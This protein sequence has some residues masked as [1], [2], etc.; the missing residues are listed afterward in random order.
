MAKGGEQSKT[1]AVVDVQNEIERMR[2]TVKNLQTIMMNQAI[3]P[4]MRRDLK[5]GVDVNSLG[6]LDN[7]DFKTA[8][9]MYLDS[10]HIEGFTM[11]AVQKEAY[12]YME[13]LNT[14]K[15]VNV[16]LF[17]DFKNELG[18]IRYNEK[19]EKGKKIIKLEDRVY[20]TIEKSF[21]KRLST[22]YGLQELVRETFKEQV[23]RNANPFFQSRANGKD[24]DIPAMSKSS[25]FNLVK[26]FVIFPEDNSWILREDPNFI[27]TKI[28]PLVQQRMKELFTTEGNEF[29]LDTAKLNNPELQKKFG[30]AVSTDLAIAE[31]AYTAMQQMP[32]KD[33]VTPELREK[34]VK[35]LL[36]EFQ[37][38][39]YE[40]LRQNKDTIANKLATDLNNSVRTSFTRWVKREDNTKTISTGEIKKLAKKVARAEYHEKPKVAS[41][42]A[43]PVQQASSAQQT[44]AAQ[45]LP[46]APPPPPAP[47]LNI[48][49]AAS[50]PRAVSA[51]P[52]TAGAQV[53]MMAE[54]QK[55]LA[56]RKSAVQSHAS[57]PQAASP[58][59]H[60]PLPTHN[61]GAMRKAIEHQK[62]AW[63]SLEKS[64][65]KFVKA[66]RERLEEANKKGQSR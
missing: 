34:I 35:K 51:K 38:M 33:Q 10:K 11:A 16:G 25:S 30:Q 32:K 29:I 45:A 4:V 54:L 41:L 42:E 31:I 52:T 9:D 24:T 57:E 12:S 66:A 28:S 48:S 21:R 19:E 56:E 62:S 17:K 26:P 3:I 6:Y 14:K 40:T 49:P 5:D 50:A 36:Q 43:Q 7:T 59:G 44:L 46:P 23:F 8:K 55:K 27:E 37:K 18:T 58:K 64:G 63:Q 53:D 13:S 1:T 15:G 61:A 39:D 47:P 20:G 60:M 65:G 2:D 22:V